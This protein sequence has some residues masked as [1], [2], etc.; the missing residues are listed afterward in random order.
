MEV[1]V[2]RWW[3]RPLVRTVS[4]LILPIV[5]PVLLT[6]LL[7]ALPGDPASIVCPPENCTGTEA[8]AE[9]W[10]LDAGPIHFFTE[11]LSAALGGELGNS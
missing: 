9:R 6:L 3:L 11:W 1:P 5:V 10:N 2:N 8:L 4:A 7:W